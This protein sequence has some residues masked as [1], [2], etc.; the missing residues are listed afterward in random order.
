MLA[1][2][3]PLAGARAPQVDP[4]VI[5]APPPLTAAAEPEPDALVADLQAVGL[6]PDQIDGLLQ[7][8]PRVRIRRQLEWLPA[9]QARN[10][11]ALLI[12]AVEQDWL[13]PREAA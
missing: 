13:A 6:Q 7:R 4:E 1:P 2:L 9:R 8:F 12:R 11:A 10:P 5:P 3:Q